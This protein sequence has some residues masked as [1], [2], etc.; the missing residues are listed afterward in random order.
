MILLAYYAFH[1]Q[2]VHVVLIQH[3]TNSSNIGITFFLHSLSR[4]GLKIASNIYVKDCR[5]LH[6][7]YE[8]KNLHK[9]RDQ[10]IDAVECHRIIYSD[11]PNKF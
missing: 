11:I 8:K 5:T 9:Y 2:Y 10:R 1:I 4:Q 6:K 3:N 7:T